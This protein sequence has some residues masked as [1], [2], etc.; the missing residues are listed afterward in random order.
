MANTWDAEMQ[1][2]LEK[3]VETIGVHGT[4]LAAIAERFDAVDQRLDK[5]DQRLD[6]V[7]QRLDKVDQRFDK[8]EERVLDAFKTQTEDLRDLVMKAAEGYGATLDRI[9]RT[10]ADSHREWREMF[11]VHDRVLENH[12]DRISALERRPNK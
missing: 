11:A 9:E 7:D 5:V 2:R 12:G 8:M 6:K 3:L 1:E 10:L 4:R